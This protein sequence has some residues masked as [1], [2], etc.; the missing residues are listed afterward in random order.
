M[1]HEFNFI[2]EGVFIFL[3]ALLISSGM[4]P[5][6]LPKVNL[7]YGSVADKKDAFNPI[8]KINRQILIILNL[9]E[10]LKNKYGNFYCIIKNLNINF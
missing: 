8:T 7:N 3:L 6:L 9:N 4:S 1:V 5:K 2:P 10:Y